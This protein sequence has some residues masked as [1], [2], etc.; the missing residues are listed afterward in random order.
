MCVS[1]AE[2][3]ASNAVGLDCLAW[4]KAGSPVVCAKASRLDEVDINANPWR[5]G[6]CARLS[7]HFEEP[8]LVDVFT[9]CGR[10]V[11]WAAAYGLWTPGIPLLRL[12]AASLLAFPELHD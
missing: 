4:G 12:D 8:E 2:A 3:I 7:S 9:L 10:T 6:G 1:R 11:R 5:T